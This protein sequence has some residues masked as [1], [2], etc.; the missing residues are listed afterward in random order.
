MPGSICIP[1]FNALSTQ[2]ERSSFVGEDTESVLSFLA[3]VRIR[4]THTPDLI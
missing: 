3:K 2:A 4:K 1:S